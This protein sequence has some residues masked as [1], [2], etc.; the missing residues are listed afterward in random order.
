MHSCT[1][2]DIDPNS[3]LI[4]IRYP[5]HRHGYDFPLFKLMNY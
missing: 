4:K 5:N 3:M 1:D 2:T